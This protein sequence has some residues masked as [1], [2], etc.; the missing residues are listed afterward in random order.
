MLDSSHDVPPIVFARV[1]VRYL[2]TDQSCASRHSRYTEH[3]YH[4]EISQYGFHE[5]GEVE[6]IPRTAWLSWT[7][8]MS[9]ETY[10]RLVTAQVQ[11]TIPNLATPEMTECRQ[12]RPSTSSSDHV[13]AQ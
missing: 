11:R 7:G 2:A 6:V 5:P 9:P 3:N 13:R 8:R 1:A 12:D 4:E 10:F